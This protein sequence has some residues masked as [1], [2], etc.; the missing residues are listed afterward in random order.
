MMTRKNR[1]TALFMAVCM[2]LTMAVHFALPATAAAAVEIS[3]AKEF[4]AIATGSMSGNYIQTAD[5]DLTGWSCAPIGT[6]SS[7]FKGTYDGNGYTISGLTLNSSSSYQ[8]LFGYNKGTIRNVT[9]DESCTVSGSGF[10]GAI[11]GKN[12]GTI[13][14]CISYASVTQKAA[15]E[16]GATYKIMSQNLLNKTDDARRPV[17]VKRL[18]AADPDVILLQESSYKTTGTYHW[19]EYLKANLTAYSF[20][21]QKRGT[22]DYEGTSIAYK[23][24]RFNKVKEG[25]FWLSTNP[26]AGVNSQSVA[27]DAQCIRATQWVV[28]QDKSTGQQFIFFSLHLD[29]MG[30]TAREEGAKLN[31]ARLNSLKSQYPNAIAVLGGDFNCNVSSVPYATINTALEGNLDDTRYFNESISNNIATM[32]DTTTLEVNE[33]P[34]VSIDHIF[35]DIDK[36]EVNSFKVIS[37]T[38]DNIAPS[39]HCGVYAE[40]A[41]VCNNYVGAVVGQ[42]TGTVSR[43]VAAGTFNGG[44]AEGKGTFLGA[45]NCTGKLVDCHSADGLTDGLIG[46]AVTVTALPTTTSIELAHGLGNAF[47][48]E[49]DQYAMIDNCSRGTLVKTY[50]NGVISYQFVGTLIKIERTGA[51]GEQVFVNGQPFSGDAVLVPEEGIAVSVARPVTSVTSKVTS[52]DYTISNV[53]EWM[54]LYNRL[55]FFQNRN[56][57]IHLLADINL[58]VSNATSFAGFHNPYFSFDGHGHTVSNFG[59]AASPKSRSLFRI[60]GSGNCGMNYIRNLTMKNCHV[61]AGFTALLYS[62]QCPNAGFENLPRDLVISG[63]TIDSCSLTAE[64]EANA[65]ILSRYG[66]ANRD[67]L[68]TIKG[69]VVKNCTLTA[70]EYAHNGFIVGKMRSGGEIG[71]GS[72]DIRDCCIAGNTLTASGSDVGLVCGSAEGYTAETLT[73]I[74]IFNN[75]LTAQK[76]AYLFADRGYTDSTA[77]TMD[78]LLIGGN[79]VSG[80]SYLVAAGSNV[81]TAAAGTLGKLYLD[82]NVTAICEGQ[83]I[84]YSTDAANLQSGKAGYDVNKSNTDPAI[85]WAKDGN[86]YKAADYDGQIRIVTTRNGNSI[87]SQYANGGDTLTLP[88]PSLGSYQV[89]EGNGSVSG[90]TLTIS[91]DRDTVVSSMA[92]VTTVTSNVSAG[93]YTVSNISEWMY[94]F[95]NRA[96]FK[97]RNVTIHLLCDLDLSDSAAASFTNFENPGFSFNGHGHTIKNWGTTSARKAQRGMFYITEG[98]SGMNFIKNISFK[99]CHTGGAAGNEALVVS[100]GQGNGGLSGLA[101][102]FTLENIHIDGC[103]MNT[104]GESAAMLLSRYGVTSS[105]FTVNILNCSVTNCTMNAGSG[106]HKGMLIGK[107]RSTGV[108]TATFNIVD[109][110]VANNTIT[111]GVQGTGI[112]FGTAEDGNTQVNLENVGIIGNTVTTN[113]DGAYIGYSDNSKVFLNNVLLDSNTVNAGSKYLIPVYTG[114]ANG[115]I[116]TIYSD[117]TGLTAAVEGK[118]VAYS[119]QVGKVRS[120]EAAYLLNQAIGEAAIYW[121][122]TNGKTV[123]T[124]WAHQMVKIR[125]FLPNN[126]NTV[127]TLYENGLK[128][129]TLAVDQDPD[130]TF[131]PCAPAEMNGNVLTVP[132]G[133]G[134]LLVKVLVEDPNVFLPNYG[135]SVTTVTAPVTKG[136]YT[137]ANIEE[138]MYVYEHMDYFAGTDVLLMLTADLDLSAARAASFDGFKNASFS[139]DGNN[140]ALKNWTKL[141]EST[142]QGNALFSE[143]LGDSIR[144]LTLDGFKVGGGYVRGILVGNYNGTNSLQISN[145]HIKN[146]TLDA[147]AG[148]NQMG[149]FLARPTQNAVNN[150]VIGITNCSVVN[151]NL[152]NSCKAMINNA[153]FLIGSANKGFQ[154]KITNVSIEGSGHHVETGAAGMVVGA[155]EDAKTTMVMD[156]V[157]IFGCTLDSAASNQY[158]AVFVGE[159]LGGAVVT[160]TNCLAGDVRDS[161]KKNL[162]MVKHSGEEFSVTADNCYIDFAPRMV[163]TT[164][165]IEGITLEYE[166]LQSGIK[167]RDS[168]LFRNGSVA[169]ECNNKTGKSVWLLG[170]GEEHGYPSVVAAEGYGAP[171]MVS[172]GNKGTYYTNGAGRLCKDSHELLNTDEGIWYYGAS[173][174]NAGTV[175][176]KDSGLVFS[177]H[178]YNRSK[179]TPVDSKHHTVSCS[180]NCGKTIT[181]SCTFT[182]WT[183]KTEGGEHIHIKSCVCGNSLKRKCSFKLL[184]KDGI[185]AV[186]CVTCGYQK[187]WNTCSNTLTHIKGTDTHHRVCTTCGHETEPVACSLTSGTVKKASLGVAGS[188]TKTCT[189]GCGNTQVTMITAIGDVNADATLNLADAVMLMRVLSGALEADQIDITAA[190][191]YT[192]D[193]ITENNGLSVADVLVILKYVLNH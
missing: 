101:T 30:A 129:V 120:G 183:H 115:T 173:R 84:T 149:L 2:V 97:N 49:N 159:M 9:L 39:D 47:T 86:Y 36:A 26:D 143:Y 77:V 187:E 119:A 113:N 146:S 88:A 132:Q 27:W 15:T 175:F 69:C 37:D 67:F 56:I 150:A 54:Y 181:E 99:N 176:A 124:D 57:T 74:G 155:V 131:E 188:I 92:S 180:N 167:Q 45:N 170:S 73:N 16:G 125:L 122:M 48:V 112:V 20:V 83:E 52:G 154:Y 185:H 138:W 29:H 34:R 71:V 137:V 171:Y 191:A 168:I 174:A 78:K 190:N 103:S 80:N 121:G 41:P 87:T 95:N 38:Y 76:S 117:V 35:V 165:N 10:T 22:S 148:G 136:T 153:G 28:L 72:F 61:K 156:H 106:A 64:G 6:A 162:A 126:G 81:T 12:A 193:E 109:C 93:D 85:Y 139:L 14:N 19:D 134:E 179:A 172:F 177:T 130:A 75:T 4:L 58:S 123:A 182:E 7:P 60:N 140:F 151:T 82:K 116:G 18:K 44:S 147:T 164:D 90:T 5:I 59:T 94:L 118:N 102:T 31:V 96:K 23:T 166:G 91:T 25:V 55:S 104:A 17:M 11:A 169:W 144:N 65:M 114:A 68:V 40:I 79:T 53:N 98:A 50:I 70:G 33:N 89:T 127:K 63:I 158:P 186:E 142:V 46:T 110:Y 152:E 1:W 62:V 161:G 51:T 32:M 108:A 189:K 145:V 128:Q 24:S 192:A 160:Y 42:N 21:G 184:S 66:V 111:N 141:A 163:R 133:G 107:P 100:V 135:D 13:E 157:G 178:N 105:G 3:T 8:G 43:T